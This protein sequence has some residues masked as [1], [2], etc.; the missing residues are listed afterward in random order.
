MT[1]T[2][3]TATAVK[4]RSDLSRFVVHLTRDDTQDFSDGAS[5]ADNFGSIVE[6]RT[7]I[8]AKPHCLHW[9]KIPRKHKRKFSVCCFTEVPLSELHL[10][11]REIPGRQVR[12]S[13]YGFVFSRDF[14]ISKGA[15]PALYINSYNRN[16]YLREAADTLYDISKQKDFRG[17]MLH[18]FLPY[19][20]AMNEKYDFTWE[21][22][23]RVLGN[24][25]FRPRD[26]VCVVLPTNG[27]EDWRMK[28]M[29]RGVPV[30]SP[31]WSTEEIV[32]ELSQQARQA[33]RQWVAKKK[34]ARREKT[35]RN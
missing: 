26:I 9:R 18:R 13:E 21:R 25:V 16:D 33:R 28:F 32:W 19:L 34:K 35:Q 29:Q 20:N 10:L 11:T 22:E 4:G 8:A 14:L 17:G 5:A 31:G 3:R 23:W 1:M 15:Q 24:L 7:I 30:I 27:A 6:S 2:S 12:L